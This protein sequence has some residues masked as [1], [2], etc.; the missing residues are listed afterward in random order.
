MPTYFIKVPLTGPD[1]FL[2]VRPGISLTP[3]KE[4]EVFGEKMLNFDEAF[5]FSVINDRGIREELRWFRSF[6]ARGADWTRYIRLANRLL[7]EAPV[8]G[9]KT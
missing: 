6:A 1:G 7:I 8:G 2:P 9:A 3:G 4:Y 5:L